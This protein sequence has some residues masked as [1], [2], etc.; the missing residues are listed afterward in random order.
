MKLSEAIMLGS[1]TCKMI[2]EDINSCALGVACN[3][4]GIPVHERASVTMD[5]CTGLGRFASLVIKPG[6]NRYHAVSRLWPWL[7]EFPGLAAKP[8]YGQKITRLFDTDV[9]LGRMTLE[10]LADYVRSVE[11]ECGECNQFM[12]TCVRVP[13]TFDR[14]LQEACLA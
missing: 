2:P 12:C 9:C 6:F 4:L 14:R 5:P 8:N 10:Q 3:A 11:P 13:S 7:N 1:T